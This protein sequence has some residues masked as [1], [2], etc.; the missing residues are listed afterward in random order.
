MNP[1]GHRLA[2]SP[3][4]SFNFFPSTSFIL[5]R[6][7]FQCLIETY[8]NPFSSSLQGHTVATV[9]GATGPLR[10]G[11]YISTPLISPASGGAQLVHYVRLCALDL[12]LWICFC[13]RPCA[14]NTFPSRPFKASR[15]LY[16]IESTWA[17]LW[18]DLILLPILLL[19]G[20]PF[21]ATLYLPLCV[22]SPSPC[23]SC[24]LRVRKRKEEGKKSHGTVLQQPNRVIGSLS[25]W[26]R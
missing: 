21:Y 19:S 11:R 14:R 10:R 2:F 7:P 23:V 5:C 3:W 9:A 24:S 25:P 13:R 6:G 16:A 8:V 17:A 22:S 1:R 4:D 12:T 18:R 20:P 26:R 15:S